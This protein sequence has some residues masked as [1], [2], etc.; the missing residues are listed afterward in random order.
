MSRLKINVYESPLSDKI[1]HSFNNM[2]KFEA[3]TET[4]K[5]LFADQIEVNGCILLGWDELYD[6]V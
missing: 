1:T 3:W 2:R 5:G 4:Q 6:F